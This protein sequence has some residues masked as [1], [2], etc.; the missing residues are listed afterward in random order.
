MIFNTYYSHYA[1]KTFKFFRVQYQLSRS[2]DKFVKHH[3]YLKQ[4]LFLQGTKLTMHQ[5]KKINVNPTLRSSPSR[6]IK[7]RKH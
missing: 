4:A 7:N 1:A 3:A 6:D 2:Y 5:P